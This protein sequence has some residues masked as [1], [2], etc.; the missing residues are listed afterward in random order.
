MMM[1]RTRKLTL[2]MRET[3]EVTKK[4]KKKK[5]DR[6]ICFTPKRRHYDRLKWPA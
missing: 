3:M 1:T 4:K 2:L 5:K 6:R